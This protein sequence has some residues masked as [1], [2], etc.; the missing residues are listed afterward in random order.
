M[1]L[2]DTFT[3]DK[4][5][6]GSN[7]GRVTDPVTVLTGNNLKKGTVLGKILAGAITET[8]AG[9]TGN[10]VMGAVTAGAKVKAG[11]YKLVITTAGTNT[12]RFT[13]YDPDGIEVG[14][15]NVATAFASSHLNFTLA[16]G[17]TDFVAGDTFLITVAAGSGKVVGVDSTLTNGAAFPYGVLAEDVDATSADKVGTCYLTGQFLEEGLI[18]VNVSDTITTYRALLRDLNI[19]GRTSVPA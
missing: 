6:G 1:S 17:A 14:D 2:L 5:L 4:L 15:G 13:L 9:N 16:D 11:I 10:G 3:Y 12:G 7:E 19:F 8:H 18:F